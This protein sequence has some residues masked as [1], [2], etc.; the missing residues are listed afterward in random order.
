MHYYD[1]RKNTHLRM[2]SGTEENTQTVN[3]ITKERGIPGNQ[4]KVPGKSCSKRKTIVEA[5]TE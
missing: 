4:G 1:A 2:I 3:D 5:G